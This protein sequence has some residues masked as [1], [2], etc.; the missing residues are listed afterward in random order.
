MKDIKK[1]P[2]KIPRREKYPWEK[3]PAGIFPCRD[4]SPH[5]FFPA[6]IFPHGEKT[7]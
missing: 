6:G 2:G 3:I 1:K 4:F 7:N 5:G